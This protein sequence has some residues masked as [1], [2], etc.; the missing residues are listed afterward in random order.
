MPLPQHRVFLRLG[1]TGHLE[2]SG[3]SN[4]LSGPLC[5]T[6][7]LTAATRPHF[8]PAKTAFPTFVQKLGTTVLKKC[9]EICI[10]AVPLQQ[11]YHYLR[12][13]GFMWILQRKFPT[14]KPNGN[15]I[16]Y[17]YFYKV[18]RIPSSA[19]IYFNGPPW[20]WS[21]HPKYAVWK[22]W[23]LITFSLPSHRLKASSWSLY[24]QCRCFKGITATAVL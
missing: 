13:K 4:P 11:Y 7:Q 17:L 24:S 23:S 19:A 12:K 10:A 3:G 18:P 5:C 22:T 8:Q 6:K 20:L 1:C 15:V 2:G 14:T 9:S 16:I 21:S